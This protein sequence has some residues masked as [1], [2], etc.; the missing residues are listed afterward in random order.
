M[1]DLVDKLRDFARSYPTSSLGLVDTTVMLE[2]AADT[3]AAQARLLELAGTLAGAVEQAERLSSQEHE[4]VPVI[5]VNLHPWKALNDAR[6]AFTAAQAE[7]Q[8]TG[9]VPCGE[10]AK[11]EAEIERLKAG[12]TESRSIAHDAL[13]ERDE[14]RRQLDTTRAAID[15]LTAACEDRGRQI[16]EMQAALD[17]IRKE[18]PDAQ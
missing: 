12:W 10:C 8:T 17:A 2:R 9:K 6:I 13:Q 18:Q 5:Q 4:R 14:A 7:Y 11:W 15:E 1:S 3:L 16:A